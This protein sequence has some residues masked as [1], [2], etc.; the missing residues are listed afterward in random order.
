M[1][2]MSRTM[3]FRAAPLAAIMLLAACGPEKKSVYPPAVT[4][5]QVAAKPG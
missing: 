3:L 1:T 4:L 5:Q 2:P